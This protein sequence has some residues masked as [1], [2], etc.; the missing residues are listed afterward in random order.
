MRRLSGMSNP[1][2]TVGL[3]V[4]LSV[5]LAGCSSDQP[6]PVGPVSD[7]GLYPTVKESEGYTYRDG[8]KSTDTGG[9]SGRG[10]TGPNVLYPRDRTVCLAPRAALCPPGTRWSEGSVGWP[11]PDT[12]NSRPGPTM[13]LIARCD[14]PAHNRR[15]CALGT[16]S[17]GME[18]RSR[19]SIGP[20][21]LYR[22]DLTLCREPRV[23]QTA[24]SAKSEMKGF[25]EPCPRGT[26]VV[27]GFVGI[28]GP[29]P[30][31]TMAV[32]LP[33]EPLPHNRRGCAR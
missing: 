10:S 9:P 20:G 26:R 21:V 1:V 31:P 8:G 19:G 27:D 5:S 2:R 22:T 28:D 32:I 3:L 23:S 7:G 13:A 14:P 15:N 33:C 30:G 4:A 6:G 11:P 29:R 17:T 24:A 18:P 12:R 25:T 16:G